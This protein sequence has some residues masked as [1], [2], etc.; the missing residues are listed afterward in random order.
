MVLLTPP[1]TPT[2]LNT[3]S[4]PSYLQPG[5]LSRDASPLPT[6]LPRKRTRFD[7]DEKICYRDP[8]PSDNSAK[9]AQKVDAS[10]QTAD[11]S[12]DTRNLLS[13]LRA[14]LLAESKSRAE[15]QETAKQERA[16]RE[17]L[18]KE[19]AE[20]RYAQTVVQQQQA[21]AQVWTAQ[22]ATY[23]EDVRRQTDAAMAHEREE[24]ALLQVR[25]DE[26][27]EDTVR[28]R[29]LLV[30]EKAARERLADMLEIET[31]GRARVEQLLDAQ[32]KA[33]QAAQRALVESAAAKAALQEEAE[34]LR[35]TLEEERKRCA[36]LD[37]SLN[38]EKME[39]SRLKNL[40]DDIARERK[41][42]FIVPGILD[43]LTVISTITDD[44]IRE[45]A[46]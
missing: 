45:A 5:R 35:A 23:Y 10:M 42:P 41:A 11:T 32:T 36:E 22:A 43:V 33:G 46:P 13:Q 40:L 4:L 24:R 44:V 9:V 26:E 2:S 29:G 20:L 31:L 14:D 38:A 3:Q 28:L 25:L 37:D 18:E 8:P 6:S 34:R 39:T 19:L 30:D 12:E 15:A 21:A 16:A 1:H 7:C 17:A 27:R